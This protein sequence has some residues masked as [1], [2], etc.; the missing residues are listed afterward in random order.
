[1]SKQ[2]GIGLLL[3]AITSEVATSEE[4]A[5][6]AYAAAQI[7]QLIIALQYSR[8]DERQAD[9]GG[10]DYMVVAGYNPSGMVETMQMLENENKIRHVEF[11]SSHPS[12]Q[13]R[14]AYLS[15]KIQSRNF[16]LADLRIGKET[17]RTTIL[18]RLPNLP[19]EKS[20]LDH[21]PNEPF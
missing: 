10:I 12:P 21:L 8:Q 19:D 17:Y 3:T 13:N 18:E 20:P 2:I 4:S 9:L 7:A 14:I 6:G 1:M 11:L 5:Q 16:P 15:Y